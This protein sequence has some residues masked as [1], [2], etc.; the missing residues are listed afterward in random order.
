ML[1]QPGATTQFYGQGLEWG[2]S[3]NFLI[4]LILLDVCSQV[5]SPSVKHFDDD[6]FYYYLYMTSGHGWVY[7]LTEVPKMGAC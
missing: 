5:E 6:S 4:L 7:F 3:E 2:G 1:P